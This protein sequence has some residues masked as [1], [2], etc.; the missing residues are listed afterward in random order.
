M[1]SDERHTHHPVTVAAKHSSF[2][3]KAR[4]LN[5]TK[6]FVVDDKVKLSENVK[7]EEFNVLVKEELGGDADEQA[8]SDLRE[9]FEK[10]QLRTRRKVR[11]M[12]QQNTRKRTWIY[13]LM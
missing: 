3:A 13:I 7:R 12:S 8:V 9:K 1:A 6:L 4:R 2:L 11:T 10:Q 5:R